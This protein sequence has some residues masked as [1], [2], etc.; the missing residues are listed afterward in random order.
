M[1]ALLKEAA[2]EGHVR[3][4]EVLEPKAQ[5]GQIV[6]RVEAAGICG[7]DVHMLHGDIKL[8][9]RPPVIMGHE[10]SGVIE[11]VGEG[12]PGWREGE[13]VSSETTFRSCGVC[14]HC[15]T[16]SY[17]LCPEKALI[18]YVYNGCFAPYL[19][20][21]A[22]RVHRIPEGLSFEECALLEPLACCVHAACE[23]ISIPPGST[24]LVAGVGAIGQLCAQLA[25]VCGA[26]VI[27]CGRTADRA[28]LEIAAELGA[29]RALSVEQEDVVSLMREETEGEGVDVFLECSGA[30]AAA[31]LGL[32]ALRRGGSYCQVGLFGRPLELD[33]EQV[34]YKE[35]QVTGSLGSRWTSWRTALSLLSAGRVILRPLVGDPLPLSEWREAFDRFESKQGL[36]TLMRPD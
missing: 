7:S 2:G 23:L 24:A 14:R 13:R 17:N 9:L 25:R 19:V 16:G 1:K 6:I 15:R 20:V 4:A 27:V 3:L 22:E 12:V 5:P 18:G 35:L 29:E 28:R 32:A 33:F 36:K 11:E 26:R 21:P 10:F 31:T 34:A 30:P 8:N